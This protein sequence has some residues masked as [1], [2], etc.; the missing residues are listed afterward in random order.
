MLSP[1][2]HTACG[3]GECG[4]GDGNGGGEGDGEETSKKPVPKSSR[5][6]KRKT[7]T[8]RDLLPN[9]C[10]SQYDDKERKF[11]KKLSLEDKQYVSILEQKIQ[12]LNNVVV[13][14]RFQILL[15]EMDEKVKAI[16]INKLNHLY[17]LDESG[18]EYYKIKNWIQAVC[19]LPIQIYKSLPV[20]WDSPLGDIRT[21]LLRTRSQLDQVV[22]GHTDAKEQIVRLLARWISNPN[23]GGMAIGIQGPMGCGKC[24]AKD[25]PILLH[26]GSVKLV[27]DIRV[28]DQ[29]MGDD[30]TPRTVL[31]LGQGHDDLYDVV[32]TRGGG[33][34]YRVNGDH[35]LCLTQPACIKKAADG[36]GYRA[37]LYDV[38]AMDFCERRFDTREEALRALDIELSV[39]DCLRLPLSVQRNWFRGLRAGVVH[40]AEAAL[41]PPP[42]WDPY[43]VGFSLAD[44]G[45]QWPHSRK[46]IPA[47]YKTAPFHD[48]LAL[49]AGILD[50]C[51]N[52]R[53]LGGNAG[54]ITLV[55]H[56][57]GLARDALFVARTLG[58]IATVCRRTRL[59]ISSA[60]TRTGT[61]PL[62]RVKKRNDTDAATQQPAAAPFLSYGIKVLPAGPG[63]YYGFTLDGNHRYLLGDM[64]VTHNTTL[65]KDG[66]CKVLGL[67]FAFIPL[68]GASDGCYLDGHSYTYEGSTWGK[69]VDTLMKCRCMNPVFYFD[70]L[71]KISTSHKGDE[72]VN[73]LIHLTDSS[74]NDSFTDKYFTDLQFDLSKSLMI[75][76]YNDDSLVHPILRDR[77][78]RIHTSGYSNTDKIR[79]ARDYMFPLILKQYNFKPDDLVLVE[80]VVRQIIESVD[81]EK[82]VRN[83]KRALESIV[84]HLNLNRIL[85]PGELTLPYILD[86]KDVREYVQNKRAVSTL[87]FMYT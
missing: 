77:L 29:V 66:I 19:N 47:S 35:I 82:G 87:P 46:E 20:A 64:T 54:S 14:M 68:G 50:G 22:Y 63:A 76:S 32:P 3:R 40:F 27:Q 43:Q 70:E 9:P 60:A 39:R 48:R 7:A 58:F 37:R 45:S 86:A 10:A 41:P 16:A 71:D 31:A 49:L 53:M 33:D 73:I 24:H 56:N 2:P 51:G 65:I 34:V 6:R 57:P 59:R 15:S 18:S 85:Q 44:T 62:R 26:S 30:G 79:I 84:S 11:Y 72:I 81:D 69:V 83:L 78:I 12:E 42:E 67:P 17:N 28:G 61:L 1:A 25:T 8:A 21:F 75:F 5:G 36:Q 52:A 38:A 74:Q 80:A 4:D 23:A 55:L 13:P